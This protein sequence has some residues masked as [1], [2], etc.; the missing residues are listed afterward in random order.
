MSAVARPHSDRLLVLAACAVGI[1]ATIGASLPYPVLP[2]LFADG[3]PSGLNSWAGLPPKLLYS[4]AIAINPAGL[5]IGS[6]L[7]GPLSDRY[8]RRHI[9]LFTTSTAALG[10]LVTAWSLA[11]QNYPLFLL[12]RFITGL[13]EGNASVARALLAD[14]LT[15]PARARAFASFNGALYSG[16]FLGPLV[17]GV[18]VQFGITVPFL[19]ASGTLV[20]TGLMGA[21]AFRTLPPSH[22]GG[23]LWETVAKRH[24]L[25]LLRER[26]IRRLFFSHLAYT[27]GATAYYEFFPVWLVEF[28][29][30]QAFGIAVLIAGMC[31]VMAVTSILAG[32]GFAPPPSPRYLR[33]YALLGALLIL[34]TVVLGPGWGVIPLLLFGAP[35]ALYNSILPVHASER[36]GHFG[37]GG[38]MGLI[39]TTY[40]ISNIAT[41]MAGGGIALIDTRL[42]LVLGAG[43]VG[44]AAW[45]VGLWARDD[46][47]QAAVA[48]AA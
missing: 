26:P 14:E 24:A 9:L 37:Q 40:C 6:T 34:A 38:V 43:A 18:L 22:P 23:S 28:G 47:V 45:R 12:A 27:L 35:N 5:L 8:G 11:I 41:A 46:R 2:P 44:F 17:A 10:H 25:L 21:V 7:L 3:Q 15:G 29:G 36:F 32:R 19:V 30:Y 16:W 42:V 31:G 39:S 33:R 1:L 48:P 4:I 13:A 20:A